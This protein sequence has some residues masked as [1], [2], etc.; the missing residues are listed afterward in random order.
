MLTDNI[1][2]LNAVILP[3]LNGTVPFTSAKHV[4]KQHQ[5]M[6]HE[7]VMDISMMMESADIMTLMATKTEILQENVDLRQLFV[8]IY[9]PNH[10][11]S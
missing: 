6:H 9:L 2:V 10:S 7:L 3:I 1:N 8:L 11:K 4:D 5:D